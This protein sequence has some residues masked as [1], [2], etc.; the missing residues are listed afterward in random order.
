MRL[1]LNRGL[2]FVP[3]SCVLAWDAFLNNMLEEI[4]IHDNM[5]VIG[6]G[7]FQGN[8]IAR[9]TIGEGVRLGWYH[10]D[11]GLLTS[12]DNG[13]DDFYRYHGSRA[14]T[15]AFRGGQWYAE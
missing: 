4:V 8:D 5:R 11:Q 10:F 6:R 9:I 12:F 3:F 7:A 15:F 1:G 14:G 2:F 13:F